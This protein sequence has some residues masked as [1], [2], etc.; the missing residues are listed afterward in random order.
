M[1]GDHLSKDT[2]EGVEQDEQQQERPEQGAHGA[3]DAQD[4]CPQRLEVA[5]NGTRRPIE[6][7]RSS[8]RAG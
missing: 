7:P 8:G 3:E 4:Q 2:T 1:I 5:R 6:A